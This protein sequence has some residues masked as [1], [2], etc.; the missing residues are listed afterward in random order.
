MRMS[1][2]KVAGIVL[3]LASLMLLAADIQA[4]ALT[5]SLVGSVT[6]ESGGVLP[7]AAVHLSSP[8]LIRGPAVASVNDKGQFRQPGLAPGSY[9]L[10]IELSGFAPYREEGIRVG[11]GEVI[12]RTVILKV[13]ARAESVA[14]EG[15]GAS[16][17]T[18]R[19]GLS[20]RYGREQLETIPVRRYSMF[21]FIKA[22]PGVASWTALISP[23]PAAAAPR[24]SPT[25]TSSRSSKSI[26]SGRRQSSET[27]R[28]PCSTP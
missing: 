16:V 21:D 23:A 4:Q 5:G 28:A 9:T 7:Q 25:S 12:E 27:S 8:A 10:S 24:R 15:S 6:D 19:S 13:A 22:A 2:V 20:S 18:R 1:Q 11:L 3:H 26:L 17:D 14:V